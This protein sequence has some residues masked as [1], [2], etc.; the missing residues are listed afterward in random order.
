LRR[1]D[2]TML[3][4]THDIRMVQELFERTIIM[5]AGQIVAAGPT[6]DLLAQT[7]L[8]EAHGLEIV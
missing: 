6:D 5:E 3:V 2:M 4:S 8:I 7:D 1:L